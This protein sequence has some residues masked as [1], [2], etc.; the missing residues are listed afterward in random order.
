MRAASLAVA[1][2]GILNAGGAQGQ[3]AASVYS[4]ARPQAPAMRAYSRPA[5]SSYSPTYGYVSPGADRSR[6]RATSPAKDGEADESVGDDALSVGMAYCVRSCDGFFFPVAQ[7]DSGS[8]AAHEAVCARTCPG[9]ET[10]LYIA[11]AGSRGIDDAVSRAGQRYQTLTAAFTFRTALDNACSCQA[12]KGV[13]PN[14]S[15]LT[16]FTLR[17]GDMVMSTEGLKMFRGGSFPYDAE[18]FTRADNARLSGQE[19]RWVQAA[20]A[21]SMRGPAGG[22]LTPALQARI[23]NQV[24]AAKGRAADAPARMVTEAPGAIRSDASELAPPS[25][26]EKRGIRYVGPDNMDV[27]P[28]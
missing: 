20:E 22:Q 2:C 26:G 15:V 16:D 23:A 8:S 17:P 5:A 9:A 21:A 27:L 25:E 10:A 24:N 28:R 3:D 11:P 19:R 1:L 12:P 4:V 18:D 6:R 7:A 14:R 13:Q